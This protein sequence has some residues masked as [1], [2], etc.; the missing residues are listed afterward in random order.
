M[1]L[2]LSRALTSQLYQTRLADP[3]TIVSAMLLLAAVAAV[4]IYLPARRA[5]RLNP[6]VALRA[7]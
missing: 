2:V 3:S 5:S 1:G 7:E 4:A 6:I